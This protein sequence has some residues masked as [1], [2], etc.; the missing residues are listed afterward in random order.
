MT[1]GGGVGLNVAHVC[2][3]VNLITVSLITSFF[4]IIYFYIFSDTEYNFPQPKIEN[5]YQVN[6]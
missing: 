5:V 4:N 1:G 3:Q 6:A 2:V